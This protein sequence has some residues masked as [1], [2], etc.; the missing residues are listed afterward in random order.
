[1]SS[2]ARH[3]L[4]LLPFLLIISTIGAPKFAAL[5]RAA[6]KLFLEYPDESGDGARTTPPPEELV[7]TTA[8]PRLAPFT[9]PSDRED[10]ATAPTEPRA[11]PDAPSRGA[12]LSSLYGSFVALQALD[13]HSTLLAVDRGA[14]E[15]NPLI[16][17]LASRPAALIAMKAGTAAGVIYMTER[18]RRHNRIAAMVLMLASN[19]A[20]A[21]LVARN[22]RIAE[23]LR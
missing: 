3:A 17:G 15:A 13:A 1:M 19:S 20:Y 14:V 11:V 9:P 8:L 22:Y 7:V 16:G 21:T 5:E 12:V 10:L 2:H 23:R 6:A 18:V 4:A